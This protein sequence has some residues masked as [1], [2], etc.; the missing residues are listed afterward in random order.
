MQHSK[1]LRSI[2]LSANRPRGRPKDTDKR[3]A[4][5][6][7]AEKLFLK[8]GLETVKIDD[9]AK[10]AGVSKMTVYANFFDKAALF[11]AVVGL[12]GDRFDEV[13]AGFEVSGDGPEVV[14]TR[15]GTSFMGFL[16]SDELMRFDAMLSAEMK[17]HPGL[18]QRFYRAGPSRMW[19]TVARIIESFRRQG[20]LAS[21]NAEQAAEDLLSLWLGM[22][23]L[24]HRFNERSALS[25]AE[26][27]GRVAHGIRLFMKAYGP[28]A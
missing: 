4:I 10:A 22:V 23:P 26:I 1:A 16:M 15:L 11:E 13:F 20:K 3:A 19:K 5:L 17:S 14:L 28:E 21:C 7:F 8:H 27:S 2:Q 25:E 9:I 24:Q 6:K 12:Q 18:G